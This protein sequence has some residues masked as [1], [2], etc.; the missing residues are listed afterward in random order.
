MTPGHDDDSTSLEPDLDQSLG[1]THIIVMMSTILDNTNRSA[2]G[3]GT[4]VAI[5]I[6]TPEDIIFLSHDPDHILDPNPGQ[7]PISHIMVIRNQSLVKT[8]DGQ[9]ETGT[10]QMTA[11]SGSTKILSRELEMQREPKHG[12]LTF[13]VGKLILLNLSYIL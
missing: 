11:I 9:M 1:T 7:G 10:D 3:P 2:V 4:K 8:R 5:G 6:N 13:Q 12:S